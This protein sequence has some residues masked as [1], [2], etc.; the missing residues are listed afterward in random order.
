M[1]E[2]NVGQMLS[3]IDLL[4]MQSVTATG[5]G[6]G[7]DVQQFVGEISVLLASKAT[8]GT[9]PTLDVKLQDS[10]DNST[11]ADIAG[12]A[13]TQVTD[14]GSSAAVLHKITVNVGAVKRYIRAVKTIGGTASP[15]FMTT[16]VGEGVK[17]V[18]A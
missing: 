7:V 13:F 12:A 11:F 10:A 3:T 14:A 4:P 15:A 1:H 2:A 5:N 9:T 6:T 8:A 18:I 17:Q 16:C